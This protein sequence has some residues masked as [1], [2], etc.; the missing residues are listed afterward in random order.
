MISAVIPTYRGGERLRRNLPSVVGSLAASGEAW[1]VVIVDDGG[2]GLGPL[3]EGVRVVALD[4]NRG[5]GPAVN[6]GV[7]ATST[8][9]TPPSAAQ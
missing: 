2:G 7:A 3:P 9:I 8:A 6:A 5:Y 1:E 4:E